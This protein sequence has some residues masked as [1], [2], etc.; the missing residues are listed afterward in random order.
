MGLLLL[1]VNSMVKEFY[2]MKRAL[3]PMVKFVT[4]HH[5]LSESPITAFLVSVSYPRLD[6]VRLLV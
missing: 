5:S 3:D 1:R 2:F 4:V 6:S